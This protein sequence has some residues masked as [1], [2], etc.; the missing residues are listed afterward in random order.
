MANRP[1]ILLLDSLAIGIVAA[2]V[3]MEAVM[4][5]DLSGTGRA[6][7]ELNFWLLS[8]IWLHLTVL[9]T[10]FGTLALLGREAD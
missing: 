6:M 8:F 5:L 9:A 2:T 4:I 10:P 1:L 7:A 3:L